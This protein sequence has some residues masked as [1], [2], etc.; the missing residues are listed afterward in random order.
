MF[1]N[2]V[3]GSRIERTDAA[4]LSLTERDFSRNQGATPKLD[5]KLEAI[6]AQLPEL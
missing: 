4:K 6:L 1:L 5:S 2:P 3:D